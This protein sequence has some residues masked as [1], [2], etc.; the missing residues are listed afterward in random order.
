MDQRQKNLLN[1]A[2]RELADTLDFGQISELLQ[3]ANIVSQEKLDEIKVGV[4]YTR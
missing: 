3:L 4:I 2:T 1:S